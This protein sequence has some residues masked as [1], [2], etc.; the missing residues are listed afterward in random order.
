LART[1]WSSGGGTTCS[2]ATTSRSA[3]VLG[4]GKEGYKQIIRSC[5]LPQAIQLGAKAIGW[6]DRTRKKKAGNAPSAAASVWPYRD[7]G[8]PASRAR[9]WA[10]PP[11]RWNEDASFNL[12]MGAT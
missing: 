11:R 5:G 9:T 1:R 3:E 6:K 10:P 8:P 7:A 2:R 12:L 4:E